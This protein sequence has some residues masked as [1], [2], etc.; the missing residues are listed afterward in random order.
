M[1]FRFTQGTVL[2]W[3]N[4]AM[5]NVNIL[6]TPGEQFLFLAHGIATDLIFP[7]TVIWNLCGELL[8]E[9]FTLLVVALT[10]IASMHPMKSKCRNE[11]ILKKW[12]N[13]Y[14][15]E[16]SVK[17]FVFSELKCIII[18]LTWRT[19]KA[20]ASAILAYCRHTWP[21]PCKEE[22]WKYQKSH[23]GVCHLDCVQLFSVL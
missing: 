3:K 7:P 8:K 9:Y 14:S 18:P 22:N 19:S 23:L 2:P 21:A 10:V 11:K 4:W 5:S 13:V 17:C 20:T 1:P 15:Y 12:I 16:L 6:V